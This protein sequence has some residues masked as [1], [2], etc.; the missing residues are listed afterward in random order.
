M[1][2]SKLLGSSAESVTSNSKGD[3]GA[4]GG[5]RLAEDVRIVAVDLQAMAPIEGVKQLQVRFH[6]EGLVCCEY[7]PRC[8]FVM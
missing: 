2:A 3:E 1:L 7:I 4:E 5:R 6:R 8:F